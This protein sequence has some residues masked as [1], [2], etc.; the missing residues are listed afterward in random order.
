MANSLVFIPL[1]NLGL[2]V[3]PFPW[4]KFIAI[5]LP[6]YMFIDIESGKIMN[7]WSSLLL[8]PQWHWVGSFHVKLLKYFQGN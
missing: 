3:C 7:K 4:K 6:S 2:L 5:V 1:Y 8:S